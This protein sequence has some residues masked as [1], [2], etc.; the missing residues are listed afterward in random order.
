[1]E[2]RS[3]KKQLLAGFANPRQVKRQLLFHCSSPPCELPFRVGPARGRSAS[4]LYCP[5]QITGSNVANDDKLNM[6]ALYW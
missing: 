5:G 1:M 4:V 3:S 6:L 2:L